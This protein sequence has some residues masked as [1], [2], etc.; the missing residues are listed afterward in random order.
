[1]KLG[2]GAYQVTVCRNR[3]RG[4]TCYEFQ[5]LHTVVQSLYHSTLYSDFSLT[6]VWDLVPPNDPRLCLVLE[7][8]IVGSFFGWWMLQAIQELTNLEAAQNEGMHIAN[9]FIGWHSVQMPSWILI[10]W[11]KCCMITWPHH[12]KI[13]LGMCKTPKAA[14]LANMLEFY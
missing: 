1:M 7:K 6:N 13:A 3:K 12:E 8:L 9:T 5:G 10:S 11:R 4:S 14:Q 2:L